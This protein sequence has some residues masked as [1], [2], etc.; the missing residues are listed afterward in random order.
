MAG[1]LKT[2]RFPVSITSSDT[3]EAADVLKAASLRG[4]R[5]RE[6]K[7]RQEAGGGMTA[8]KVSII[9]NGTTGTAIA[10]VADED[11]T[12]LIEP[13]SVTASATAA[14]IDTPIEGFAHVKDSIE[15]RVHTVTGT[16]AWTV[17]GHIIVEH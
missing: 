1:E 9:T 17:V 16:G 12:V 6:V 13:T 10:S 8:C 2:S 15:V 5:V 14:F 7:L 3:T 4:G 11:E